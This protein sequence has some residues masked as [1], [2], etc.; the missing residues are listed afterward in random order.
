MLAAER[1][2]K[3]MDTIRTGGSAEVDELASVLQVST[4]TIRRDLERLQEAGM[5]E[6]CHGGAVL[7]AETAAADRK[8][9]NHF[10]KEKIARCA[11]ELIKDGTTVFLGSG[12][13][14]FEIALLIADRKGITAVTNDL[15]IARYLADGKPELI[16]CGGN[17]DKSLKSVCGYHATQMMSDFHFDIGFFGSAAVGSD[18]KIYSL[19]VEAAFLKRQIVGQ[20]TASYL[21][22]DESKFGKTGPAKVNTLAD[23]S[24]IITTKRFS[25]ADKERLEQ[26]GVHIIEADI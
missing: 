15:E 1:Q 8:I 3:I 24:G 22:V 21:V 5:I 11:V 25:A 26:Q 10:P 4:M 9:I 2:M 6:R 17:V 16:V 13:T 19:S 14:A 20:C 7:R 12:T 18:L 23:Y